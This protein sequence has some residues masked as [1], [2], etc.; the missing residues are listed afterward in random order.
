MRRRGTQKHSTTG[1][2]G[3]RPRGR[4]RAGS[5]R[6]ELRRVF[7]AGNGRSTGRRPRKPGHEGRGGVG[8]RR[9]FGALPLP[10]V[11]PPP[12]CCRVPILVAVVTRCCAD[13]R[14]GTAR[15]L[16]GGS[17]EH[18]GRGKG[19]EEDVTMTDWPHVTG[20]IRKKK[21]QT[22]GTLL[23]YKVGKGFPYIVRKG[24]GENQAVGV[25]LR[26]LCFF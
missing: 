21:N 18:E 24:K 23:P 19:R 7:A 8:S 9:S 14:T 4:V 3:W 6:H 12:A 2:R 10:S 25:A 22:V 5:A 15:R 16:T 1:R 13:G 20:G 26:Y 11:G 17:K